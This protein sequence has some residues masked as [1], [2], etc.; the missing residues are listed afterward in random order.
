ME[1]EPILQVLIGKALEHAQIE[2][3]EGDEDYGLKKAKDI[4]KQKKE[5]MLMNTQRKE[6]GQDRRT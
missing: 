4:Y 6:A 5:A 3:I 1:C 2:V